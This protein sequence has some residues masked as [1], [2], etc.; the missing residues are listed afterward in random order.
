MRQTAERKKL[1][2]DKKVCVHVC[3]CVCLKERRESPT[4]SFAKLMK[5]KKKGESKL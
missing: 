3:V 5:M 4:Q 2:T 1:S